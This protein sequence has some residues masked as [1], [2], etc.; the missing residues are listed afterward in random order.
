MQ[1]SKSSWENGAGLLEQEQETTTIKARRK[2]TIRVSKALL[3]GV[4]IGYILLC[5]GIVVFANISR[6][7]EGLWIRSEDDSFVQGMTVDIKKD[8][9][10]LQGVIVAMGNT[11]VPFHTGQVKWSEM[12]Q[13]GIGRYTCYDLTYD[14]GNGSYYYGAEKAEIFIEAGG[15]GLILINK[16]NGTATGQYQTWHKEDR[17]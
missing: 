10:G 1:S 12:K 8:S 3:I 7:A 13:T 5:A 15:K 6:S 17:D 14:H 11:G 9:G 16:D 4:V 2:S